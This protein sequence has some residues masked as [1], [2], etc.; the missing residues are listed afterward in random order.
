MYAYAADDDDGGGGGGGDTGGCGVAAIVGSLC[1]LQTGPR[2]WAE[3]RWQRAEEQ[4]V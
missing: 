1:L 3:G 2:V 4:Q